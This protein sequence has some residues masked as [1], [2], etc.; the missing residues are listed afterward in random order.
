MHWISHTVPQHTS[1]V[2]HPA[3]HGCPASEHAPP[4]LP[5]GGALC[6]FSTH[7]AE[8]LWLLTS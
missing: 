8:W 4:S 6:T 7:C 1:D 3:E 2:Q 5:G